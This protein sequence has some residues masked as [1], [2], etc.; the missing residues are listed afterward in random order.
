MENVM[1]N[2]FCEL[3]EQ[4]MINF[5]GGGFID[6]SCMMYAVDMYNYYKDTKY[7]ASYNETVIAG[8]RNDLVKESPSKPPQFSIFYMFTR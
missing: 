8:G 3:N 5:D 6:M 4:E 1:T 2:G 7:T